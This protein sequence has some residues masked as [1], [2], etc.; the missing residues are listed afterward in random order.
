LIT[1]ISDSDEAGIES[2]SRIYLEL[3][4]VVIGA[5]YCWKDG[6]VLYNLL[7][8]AFAHGECSPRSIGAFGGISAIYIM[9]LDTKDSHMSISR[10]FGAQSVRE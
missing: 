9:R 2:E 4:S 5:A 10:G 1:V 3:A 8:C 7:S 6:V